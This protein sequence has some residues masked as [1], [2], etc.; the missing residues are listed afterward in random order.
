MSVY[1]SNNN[2]ITEDKERRFD[3]FLNKTIVSSSKRYFKKEMNICRKTPSLINDFER[4]LDSTN[5]DF[6][7]V[8]NSL[9]L[10]KALNKLTAIEQSV[11]FLLFREEFTQDEAGKILEICSKSVSRIKIRAIK[12]LKKYLKGEM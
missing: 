7:D 12:K 2:L 4:V 3:N 10:N 8:E 5:S 11:I 9:E 6:D 1:K